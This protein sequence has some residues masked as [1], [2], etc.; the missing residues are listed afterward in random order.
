MLNL[1]LDGQPH[2]QIVDPNEIDFHAEKAGV[3]VSRLTIPAEELAAYEAKQTRLKARAEI[4][5]VAGDA[6]SILGTTADSVGLLLVEVGRF[7]REAVNSSDP[8]IANAAQ[9]LSTALAPLVDAVDNN[10]CTPTHAVKGTENCVLE[11]RDKM[12]GVSSVLIA[13]SGA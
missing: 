7:M 9:P 8:I 5:P 4:E 2:M 12:N 6:L 3:D 10:T 11:A 13:N 1:Y